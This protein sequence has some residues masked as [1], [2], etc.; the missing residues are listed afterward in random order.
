MF[1]WGDGEEI[2]VTLVNAA[3]LALWPAL[4]VLLLGYI[5]QWLVVR[6]IQP[7][8]GLRKSEMI[9]LD[10]AVLLYEQV[11]ARL[12]DISQQGE[13]PIG[14][15]R[16]F[17]G[18]AVEPPDH[19]TEEFE[20]LEAHAQHLR[21]SIRRLSSQPLQRLRSWV[22]IRCS[23]FALG[24]ALAAHVVGLALLIAVFHVF[25]ESAWA[26]EFATSAK[27]L[28]WYPLDERIFYA[29]AVA[30]GFATL[31][32]PL[33]Y[34]LRWAAL[35]REYSLEFSMFKDLANS[36]LAPPVEAPEPQQAAE[37]WQDTQEAQGADQSE[38]GGTRDW[39]AVL[40]LSQ[41]ATI[42]DVKEAYKLLIKQNH[43]DRVHGM[44]VAFKTLAEAETKKIN[45]AYQQALLSVPSH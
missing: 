41:S 34:L 6:S 37:T 40:G 4:P 21:A 39:S 31:A 10:R 43:P 5:R 18:C 27:R 45:A 44:S 42:E 23:Q 1:W 38:G 29:N 26:S 14:F 25:E 11:C 28:V 13:R 36:G 7:K 24:R 12:K 22:R 3:L 15:W 32:A 9:E 16:S 2:S 35:S 30:T 19:Q 33:F 20:D 17:F 8:F